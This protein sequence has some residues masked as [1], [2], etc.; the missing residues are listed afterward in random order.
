[1][2]AE[3]ARKMQGT[4]F[5][6]LPFPPH[7]CRGDGTKRGF[8]PAL[9]QQ[10]E[11]VLKMWWITSCTDVRRRSEAKRQTAQMSL[12]GCNCLVPVTVT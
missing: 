5:S 10:S 4:F 2:R 3:Q 9:C 6:C 1:M 7:E 12:T 11:A 8:Y